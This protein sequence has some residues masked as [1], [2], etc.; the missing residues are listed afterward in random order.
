MSTVTRRQRGLALVTVLWSVMILSAIAVSMLSTGRLATRLAVDGVARAQ[1]EALVDAAVNRAVLGLIDPRIDHRWRVDGV[2]RDAVFREY[3]VS[4]A[5][6]DEYGKI[7]LNLASD[8]TL[9]QMFAI[10]GA[11]P[12][13]ADA[14]ADA[15][16]DW[17][18]KGDLRRLHGAK[19]DDY[20]AAGDDYR[21]RGGP[22]QT[23]DELQLVMG[24][25]PALFQQLEPIVTVY[26]Q[27]QTLN[28]ET[29]PRF[30]LLSQAGMDP[31]HADA[32]IQARSAAGAGAIVGGVIGP[33]VQLAGWPFTIRVEVPM[34]GLRFSREVTIRLTGDRSQPFWL[35]ATRRTEQ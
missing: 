10:A 30:A 2:P 20:H 8:Q 21:P 7:D 17:R 33:T 25:T 15:V 28:T 27:R 22:F 5:I 6:Q 14:L 32:L 24:M 26:S 19:A 35:L 34:A 4:V 13:A 29:A 3:P 11:A 1:A 16:L 31:L 9:R 23:I 18:E 12:D